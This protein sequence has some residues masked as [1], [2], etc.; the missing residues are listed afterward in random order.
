VA[1]TAVDSASQVVTGTDTALSKLGADEFLK[2]LIAELQTQDP[3]DPMDTGAMMQE[4][5]QL[6]MVSET[7]QMREA[8]DF[9][10]AVGLIGRTVQWQDA[11]T[12]GT[13]AG[14]V[15]GVL[16]QGST[17]AIVVGDQRLKLDEVL[18]I[19]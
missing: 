19:S 6:S 14:V 11:Q 2:L 3:M 7:R 4:L 8:Q 5:S 17:A 12:G 15:D 1:V 10:Q 18:A 13:Q 9:G 16:R